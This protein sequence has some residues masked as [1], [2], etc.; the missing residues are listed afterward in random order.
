VP[1]GKGE[2]QNFVPRF[3]VSILSEL[4]EIPTLRE[5]LCSLERRRGEMVGPNG[6]GMSVE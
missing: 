2:K 1:L 4:I 5:V 3:P 6:V